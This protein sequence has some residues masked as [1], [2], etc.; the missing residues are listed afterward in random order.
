MADSQATT[1]GPRIKCWDAITSAIAA[2]TSAL[3]VAYC[4]LR[5]SNGTCIIHFLLNF[6]LQFSVR[7]RA[8]RHF[9]RQCRI[10]FQI[11]ATEPMLGFL[12]SIA[13]LW[14][15]HDSVA[16]R[17]SQTMTMAAH[18]SDLPGC[19]AGHERV[20]RYILSDHRTSSYEGVP[21]NSNSAN[22]S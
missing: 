3:M 21:S 14:T 22:D 13:T 10:L 15:Y 8:L 16:V 4:A 11:Q 12:I 5:S 9:C 20:I 18:P 1:L 7:L 6:S 2:S 17:R 19:I